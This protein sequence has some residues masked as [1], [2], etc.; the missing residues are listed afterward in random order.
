MLVQLALPLDAAT[1]GR[2]YTCPH[3]TTWPRW[4][5]RSLPVTGRCC[6]ELRR[7]VADIVQTAGRFGVDPHP[8]LDGL[9]GVLHQAQ[10]AD[11]TGY[12]PAPTIAAVRAWRD[13]G[14]R[15]LAR[16]RLAADDARDRGRVIA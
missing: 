1:D 3:G 2:A 8:A 15:A 10:H 5:E 9:P 7:A 13:R 4:Q 12:S 16:E 11:M 6:R 14:L